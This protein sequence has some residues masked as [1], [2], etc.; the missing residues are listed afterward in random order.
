[1][2]KIFLIFIAGIM[3]TSCNND[4]TKEK[5]DSLEGNLVNKTAATPSIGEL[6]NQGLESM[7]SNL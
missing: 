4:D 5:N 2:K 1:M 6:H 7:Y 3:G